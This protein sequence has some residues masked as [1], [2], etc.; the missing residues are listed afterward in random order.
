MSSSYN[1]EMNNIKDTDL[2]FIEDNIDKIKSVINFI[3]TRDE[4]KDE[5]KYGKFLTKQKKP[6]KSKCKYGLLCYNNSCNRLHPEGWDPNEALKRISQI[7]CKFGLKCKSNNCPYKHPNK[8]NKH[9][10]KQ[11]TKSVSISPLALEP[12]SLKD[13]IQSTLN[14][15]SDDMNTR[16]SRSMSTSSNTSITSRPSQ[17]YLSLNVEYIANGFGHNDRIPCRIVITDFKNNIIFDEKIDPNKS[18]NVNE[19]I[20]TL[21]PITGITM[22]MLENEGK[23]Y[24]EVIKSLKTILDENVVFIGHNVD[25]DLFRLG[26]KPGIDYK[27]YIDIVMEFRIV[28]KTNRIIKNKYFSLEEEKKILLDIDL[29]K[30]DTNLNNKFINDTIITMSIFKNWIK[31]GETKKA[32]AKK[33]LTESKFEFNKYDNN[34]KYFVVDGICCSQYRKDKCI[35]T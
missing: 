3:E 9:P 18:K 2:K 10:N 28:K 17:N 33:R 22:E 24:N 26:L 5:K 34:Y 20:S 27:N 6:K 13:N 8:P 19:V 31:P 7:T 29:E 30:E 14:S 4:E 1:I 15:F 11:R 21:E 25:I 23:S 35:C 16:S 32:R 12:L